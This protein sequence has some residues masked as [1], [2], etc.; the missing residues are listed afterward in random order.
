MMNIYTSGGISWEESMLLKAPPS[1]S[2]PKPFLTFGNLDVGEVF[3]FRINAD[4]FVLCRVTEVL[5]RDLMQRTPED[6]VKIT[7][8][9]I[10]MDKNINL[11]Q[12]IPKGWRFPREEDFFED[13]K[14]TSNRKYLLEEVRTPLY[15]VGA[16]FNGDCKVDYA[17]ILVNSENTMHAI[18][19]F[20][21]LDDG[22]Y[23]EYDYAV[24][25]WKLQDGFYIS[26]CAPGL[27]ESHWE[28]SM[29]LLNHAFYLNHFESASSLIYFDKSVYQF[30]T[31]RQSD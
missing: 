11:D 12:I 29:E 7:I 15:F 10:E 5:P 19:V 28:N 23:K 2:R 3:W 26:Y 14:M 20:L 1:S 27:L 9:W 4:E 31:W 6:V 25:N 30:K 22:S 17:C 24:L 16:D 13:G 18:K 8:E 21:E